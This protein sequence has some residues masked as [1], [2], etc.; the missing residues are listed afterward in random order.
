MLDIFQKIIKMWEEIKDFFKEMGGLSMRMKLTL[1]ILFSFCIILALSSG[2][3]GCVT[4]N[5]G[6]IIANYKYSQNALPDL[7]DYIEKDFDLSILDKE[8]RIES[9]K[10]WKKLLEQAYNELKAKE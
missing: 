6:Y 9:V 3:V 8:I 1:G 4:P 10:E 2:I 5:E 7:L